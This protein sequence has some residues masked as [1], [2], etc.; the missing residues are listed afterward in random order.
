[1][2]DTTLTISCDDCRMAGTG[3]CRDC[4]MTYVV[5]GPLVVVP[6]A[7]G[8]DG[9]AGHDAHDGPAGLDAHDGPAA[10]SSTP[11]RSVRLTEAEGAAIEVL[12]R[13]GLVPDVRFRPRIAG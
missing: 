10:S 11:T 6:A 1:M 13:A 3:A 5:G 2:P 12:H 7:V 9:P 8:T 4:L